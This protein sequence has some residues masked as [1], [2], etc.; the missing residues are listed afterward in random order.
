[1]TKVGARVVETASRTGSAFASVCF[2]A[3][4]FKAAA[5]TRRTAN[6]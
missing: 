1:M 2:D 5:I 6:S 4:S 3:A